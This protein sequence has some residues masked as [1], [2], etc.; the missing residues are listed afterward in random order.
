MYFTARLEES[1]GENEY[2]FDYL[3]KANNI[4]E[5]KIMADLL[6]SAWYGED[7]EY[8]ED[9]KIYNFF[10]GAVAVKIVEL[11]KTTKKAFTEALVNRF[12]IN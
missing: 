1:N 2:I 12:T 6:A 11:Y 7:S 3:I 4:K 10:G 5:A 9:D 8:D